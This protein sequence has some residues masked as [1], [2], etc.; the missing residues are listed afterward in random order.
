MSRSLNV[1]KKS[2]LKIEDS[3]EFNKE[4]VSV[5]SNQFKEQDSPKIGELR[6]AFEK[7][8]IDEPRPPRK[9][10]VLTKPNAI[11]NNMEVTK[12]NHKEKE[13]NKSRQ[14]RTIE[15][16]LNKKEPTGANKTDSKRMVKIKSVNKIKETEQSSCEKK[17]KKRTNV[18]STSTDSFLESKV[19][20]K[21]PRK[22]VANND[23]SNNNEFPMKI[24]IPRKSSADN[25]T[26]APMKRG[27]RSTTGNKDSSMPST[28]IVNKNNPKANKEEMNSTKAQV[29]NKTRKSELT[30]HKSASWKIH[31]IE[32]PTLPSYS[33]N[34]VSMPQSTNSMKPKEKGKAPT[35]SEKSPTPQLASPTLALLKREK[36]SPQSP[37]ASVSVKLECRR[38]SPAVSTTILAAVDMNK[39]EKSTT[40]ERDIFNKKPAN[41]KELRKGADSHSTSLIQ[42]VA[43]EKFEKDREYSSE[44][45]QSNPRSSKEATT[46]KSQGKAVGKSEG[47]DSRKKATERQRQRKEKKI[48]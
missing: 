23:K 8:A 9:R 16:S 41:K 38:L 10:R 7:M 24:P 25:L 48:S 3:L 31:K 22:R 12:E 47:E 11:Y 35:S 45:S 5:T 17:D 37:V 18:P 30:S 6:E 33:N 44:L 1:K 13:K 19:K 34:N 20:G 14:A 40:H 46:T 39:C 29:T 32:V 21:L 4:N 2:L 26:S 15:K 27:L 36:P 43:G 28:S 42:N